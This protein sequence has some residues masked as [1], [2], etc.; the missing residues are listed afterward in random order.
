MTQDVVQ[1]EVVLQ[2]N[3]TS[4]GPVSVFN[5]TRLFIHFRYL[6]VDWS[7]QVLAESA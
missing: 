3:T 1:L 5:Q 2:S 6:R 7:I 4:S